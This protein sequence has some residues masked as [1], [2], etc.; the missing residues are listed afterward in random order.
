MYYEFAIEPTAIADWRDFRY[1]VD[2]IGWPQGRL[3]VEY[4]SGWKALV[5]EAIVSKRPSYIQKQRMVERLKTLT[6]A[7]GLVN[8]TSMHQQKGTWLEGALG[9]HN[10][11]PFRAIVA[12]QR[13]SP[14]PICV[15]D[16]QNC[17][18]NVEPLL[19]APLPPVPR[20][21]TDL[22][23]AVAPLVRHAKCIHLVDPYFDANEPRFRQVFEGIV[24]ASV[25]GRAEVAVAIALHTSVER[26]FHRGQQRTVEEEQRVATNIVNGCKARLT[27]T[28]PKNVTLTVHLWQQIPNGQEL[29]NR[30][31][32]TEFGGAAFGAGLDGRDEAGSSRDD[33]SRLSYE[34]HL[35]WL[36]AYKSGSAVFGEVI[37]PAV[38]SKAC[39]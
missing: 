22:V 1:I 6:I 14:C 20:Q 8:R 19:R 26:A 27:N 2:K 17:D 35:E 13:P 28:L 21:A 3:L 11:R 37:P 4:P 10:L 34:Q 5:V 36:A 16:A 31:V 30:Y 24:A 33:V 23:A 39:R 18:E 15:V 7:Q 29:H 25:A 32:F 9:E 38:F 12:T